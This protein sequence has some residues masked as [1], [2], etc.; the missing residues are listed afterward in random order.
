[1]KPLHLWKGHHC[2]KVYELIKKALEDELTLILFPP[3]KVEFGPILEKLSYS[4]L[5]IHQKEL[6][7]NFPKLQSSQISKLN[8]N[9]IAFG[10]F[11]SGTSGSEDKLLLYSKENLECATKGIISF[12]NKY[13]PQT[14]FCY[15]GP[16]HIFGLSLGYAMS[17]LNNFKLVTSPGKYSKD[18]HKK[19]VETSKT[20]GSNMMTLGT[21]THFK[22]LSDFLNDDVHPYKT[23]TSITGGAL[24]KVSDWKLQKDKLN[25]LAPSIGYGCSEASPALTH[26]PPGIC[27]EVDGDLGHAIPN[28]NISTSKENGLEFS[29][30]NLCKHIITKNDILS[31]KSFIIRDHIIKKDNK[32]YYKGR[33]DFVLNRGGEK[34]SLE[35]IEKVIREKCK[36][37]VITFR[38][39]DKR[40]GEDLGIAIE[41][42]SIQDGTIEKIYKTLEFFY[43]RKFD[44]KKIYKVQ[45]F[46]LN[47][48]QKIDRLKI[49][50]NYIGK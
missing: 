23:L 3:R 2:Q 6:E 47:S 46:P 22:D 27:P 30:D 34:F 5:T 20:H 14:I 31:P 45:S 36:L 39:P 38:I 16:Y 8:I 43:K 49:Q 25:I 44:I 26:L 40:L 1:M 7:E 32:F 50:N 11:S 12:F 15:P 10:I 41:K 19:W 4:S 29:G 24:V 35:S 21:P 37:E 33:L 42:K 18:A 28:V 48:S 13:K 17:I 9:D